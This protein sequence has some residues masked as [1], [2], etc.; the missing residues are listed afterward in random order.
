M[1]RIKPAI[2]LIVDGSKWVCD[3]TLRTIKRVSRGIAILISIVSFIWP[4]RIG[5]IKSIRNTMFILC[6][7]LLIVLDI[8]HQT[9]SL[10][11]QHICTFFLL[12]LSHHVITDLHVLLRGHR[13]CSNGKGRMLETE[14]ALRKMLFFRW[15]PVD[16]RSLRTFVYTHTYLPLRAICYVSTKFI[17]WL[18]LI[19]YELMSKLPFTI[20]TQ[21]WSFRDWGVDVAHT[22]FCIVT[23]SL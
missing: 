12:L 11:P 14:I 4:S 1:N 3:F 13:V 16:S 2:I 5:Q 21:T 20:I 7:R 6:L 18:L 15:L 9:S 23:D 8:N 19:L 10:C 17:F 22:A